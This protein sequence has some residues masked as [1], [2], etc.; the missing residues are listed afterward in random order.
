M[1]Y[2]K[3]DADAESKS[4]TWGFNW[5]FHKGKVEPISIK[6]LDVKMGKKI[7]NQEVTKSIKSKK[8]DTGTM[9]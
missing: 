8:L 7:L 5:N 4:G 1:A 6:I 9:R 3:G 2:K